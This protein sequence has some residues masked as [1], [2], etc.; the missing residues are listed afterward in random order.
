MIPIKAVACSTLLTVPLLAEATGL[1]VSFEP[2]VGQADARVQYL[3]RGKGYTLF[4]TAT[5]VAISVG[6]Q[7]PLC[8]VLAGANPACQLTRK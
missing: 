4:L 3:A 7:Q 2:N 1:P 5:E 8:M 6:G